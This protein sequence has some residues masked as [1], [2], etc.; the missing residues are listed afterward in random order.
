[1]N[2]FEVREKAEKM[3]LH[4]YKAVQSAFEELDEVLHKENCR[5]K[6]DH[7]LMF[8]GSISVR[9]EDFTLRIPITISPNHRSVL[10]AIPQKRPKGE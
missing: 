1:M 8:S 6:Y 7:G 2:Y 10:K 4:A 5:P 9:C 3:E